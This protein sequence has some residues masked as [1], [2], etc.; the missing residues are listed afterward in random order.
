MG[1][2]RLFIIILVAFLSSGIAAQTSYQGQ[3][4]SEEQ[5]EALIGA[6]IFYAPGKGVTT[7]VE[8][9]FQIEVD[10][11]Y[12]ILNVNYLGYEGL[13]LALNPEKKD[14]GVLY[15]K[16]SSTSLEEI[17]VSASSSQY[18]PDFVGS[19]FRID[20]IA[21]RNLNPINTEELLKSVPGVNIIGDMGISN[22]PNISIRGSWGRRSKKV[23]LMEDGSPSAPAPYIAPGAYYNPVSDRLLAIEVYKGAD[24]L[25]YG[26]NNMYG[27]VN[28]ITALPPQ[29]PEFRAKLIGGQ[30]NYATALMSYG[31]TWNNLG[32]LVEGVYKH[33]DGF[34]DNSQ[35]D[36][37][38]LNAK[39]FAQLNENQSIYFKVSGQIEDNQASLSSQTPFT[40][41]ADPTQNPFDADQFTMRRY[42]LD[43]IH[44]WN[45]SKNSSLSSKIYSSDFERDWWRQRSTLVLASEARDYLGEEI[46]NDRYS[47]LDNQEF[48]D[49]DI[50][51]VGLLENGRESTT[52]SRWTFT[53]T[54]LQET[55][56]SKWKLGG[57]E[58]KLEAA[59][60]LHREIYKDRFLEADSSRWARS[61]ETVNDIRYRLWSF[62]SYV[63]QEFNFSAFRIVPIV[64]FEH[65]DMFRLD[66]LQQS[67]NPNLTDP[68]DG[69]LG[70]TYQ[71][72]L[73]G[74]TASWNYS[75]G[76]VFG[77]IY[78][79]F[80]APSKVFGFLIEID[81]VITNP[82]GEDAVNIGPEV[83]MNTELG[84]R[85]SFLD[86]Q[87]NFQLVAFQNRINN[88]YAGGRAEVFEELGLIR[89]RG[90]ELSLNSPIVRRNEH[91]FNVRL[92]AGL[93]NSTVLDGKL[94]DRLIFS[95]VVHS[96]ASKEELINTINADRERF[97]VFTLD[98]S[99]NEIL[100]DKSSFESADFDQISKTL[101]DF[102]VEGSDL[103]VPYTPPFTGALHLDY[104]FKD[105]S[106]GVS[107]NYIAKQ[108]TEYFNFETESADGA[109]GALPAYWT[110]DAFANY[111]I[112]TNNKGQIQLFV[113][114]KNLNNQIYRASRLNRTTSGIFPGGF[115]QI[116]AGLNLTF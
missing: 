85:G 60:K 48:G 96:E 8:G 9:Y 39:A 57:Q 63:R 116:I 54:G 83:S 6:Q 21:I 76:E 78:R 4:L 66:V 98:G 14:L 81:G 72:V 55:W 64:R 25:R 10:A 93:L 110:F 114:G 47:Y 102:G 24:M 18:D 112:K 13:Q 61:G 95:D 87:M 103:S 111:T 91:R 92:N 35:V 105:F 113:N 90:L 68:K 30:G 79:G 31:G 19:N 82:L 67:Q 88:F 71:V 89:I 32:L 101:I 33:F 97:E 45:A 40:F 44:K 42:G 74:L 38:N 34:I 77:S 53:V 2:S 37:L 86:K 73:P 26:P 100:W 49:E 29:K 65:V 115:R 1:D 59:A 20:P 43:I 12:E 108:Y 46:F 80:I 11:G 69:R 7:D 58:Q 62:S 23:L 109:I 94:N 5:G 56:K 15:L 52:D 50:V 22:R 107:G 99:G 104:R 3:V 75:S 70:N 27:A 51:R 106:M 16:L 28:Y 36:V 41:E 17:I 84:W